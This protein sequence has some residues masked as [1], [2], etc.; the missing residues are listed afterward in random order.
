MATGFP[1]LGNND[2]NATLYRLARFRSRTN[3]VKHYGAAR[4]R[5]VYKG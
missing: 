5:A 2:V 4:L 3:R 1:A